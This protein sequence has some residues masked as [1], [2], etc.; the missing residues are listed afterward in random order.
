MAEGNR[1]TDQFSRFV[2]DA[3]G[4]AQG[5]AKEVETALKSQGEKLVNKLELPS[6]EEFEALREMVI[7]AREENEALK[8]RIEA[9]ENVG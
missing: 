1:F 3:M 2:T 7:L 4:A 5:A 8:K 9:L 6:R